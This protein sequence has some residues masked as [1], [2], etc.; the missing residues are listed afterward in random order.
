MGRVDGSEAELG[1]ESTQVL[2]P[3]LVLPLTSSGTLAKTL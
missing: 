2:G 1:L 3:L